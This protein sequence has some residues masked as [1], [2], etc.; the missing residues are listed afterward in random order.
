MAQSKKTPETVAKILGMLEMGCTHRAAYG[1]ARIGR[2]TFYGW[3]RDDPEFAANVRQAE[4]QAEAA[5][6]AKALEDK[7]NFVKLMTL[8]F[9][10]D[11]GERLTL[12]HAGN[13]TVTYTN[14]WRGETADAPSGAEDGK[15]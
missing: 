10:D 2:E 1:I 15:T 11:W 4:A 9:R 8:R 7:R 12:E 13:I 5:W 14:D 3:I 6:L